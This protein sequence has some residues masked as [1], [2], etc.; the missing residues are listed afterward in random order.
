MMKLNVFL[1]L[2][3]RR[4][5]EIVPTNN[6]VN[7]SSVTLTMH[8]ENPDL[9]K[10][11]KIVEALREGAVILYPTDTGFALGCALDNKAAAERIRALR[12]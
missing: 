8:P 10:I 9:R 3:E 1:H 2:F 5:M 11:Y 4:F 6:E 12:R 7:M